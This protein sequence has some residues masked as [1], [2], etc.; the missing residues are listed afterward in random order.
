M[1]VFFLLLLFYIILH[2]IVMFKLIKKSTENNDINILYLLIFLANGLLVFYFLYHINVLIIRLE[3]IQ[4]TLI[5]ISNLLNSTN[6]FLMSIDYSLSSINLSLEVL[7]YKSLGVLDF[8]TPANFDYE[9]LRLKIRKTM[10]I[11][12]QAVIIWLLLSKFFNLGG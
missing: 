11:S 5:E 2:C 7:K 12:F 10:F 4:Q 1:I 6:S 8:P 9:S 3:N